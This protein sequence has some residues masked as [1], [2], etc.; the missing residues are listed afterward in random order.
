[1][2]VKEPSRVRELGALL[3]PYIPLDRRLA[4]A[5]GQ[6]LPERARGAAL[7][8]DISGFTPLTAVLTETL[9]SQRGAEVLTHQLNLVYG[10]LIAQVHKYG[11]SVVSFAG[12]A[13]TCWFD[14]TSHGTGDPVLSARL[15]LSCAQE[16]QQT[17]EQVD[18]MVTATGVRVPIS[19]KVAVTAGSVSRYHL[20]DPQYRIIDTLAGLTLDKLAAAEQQAQE[21]EIVVEGQTMKQLRT[22]AVASEWRGQNEEDRI[23]VLARLEPPATPR[24]WPEI[25][26]LEASQAQD[27]LLKPVYERLRR[28][29]GEYL[30][31]IRLVASLFIRFTGLDY[32]HDDLAGRKLD[33]Y[34][35]WTQAVIS[36]YQG[37][38]IQLTIGD[39]GSYLQMAFG[40]PI[41]HGD[42]AG[43]AVAA[44]LELRQLPDRLNY[45][46]D[47]QIGI[48]QGTMRTGAYGG[49][50]RRSY[51]VQG[52][53]VNIAARLMSQAQ[54]GQI[55][56]TQVISRTAA[57]VNA[58]RE[59]GAIAVKG[60]DSPVLT[61]E[62]VGE[63]TQ[64][65]ATG[66]QIRPAMIGRQS[67]RVRLERQLQNLKD[68]QSGGAI[69]EGED[70]I[71]KSR[72]VAE[73]I[74]G[75]EKLGIPALVGAGNSI[76]QNTAYHAWRSI[77]LELLG[78]E[79]GGD[80]AVL[81]EMVL[82]YLDGNPT[83]VERAPLLNSI[84]PVG[85]P[86][87][88]LTRGMSGEVRASN[89]GALLVYLLKQTK[90]A[91]DPL[92][93]ILDDAQWLDSASW[94]L[95]DRVRREMSTLLLVILLR[96]FKHGANGQ[97]PPEYKKLQG[98]GGTEFYVLGAMSSEEI[99]ALV[100]RRLGVS[101][102]PKAIQDLILERAEGH[103]LFSEEI[104]LALRDS[105]LLIV[106]GDEVSLASG[107]D[108]R[109]LDFPDTIQG[110]I[111]SRI[112][113]LEPG[114]ELTLKVASVI[115]RVFLYRTLA[116][117]Y[118]VDS[119][120]PHLKEYLQTLARLD[121]TPIESEQPELSYIFRNAITRDVVYGL[122][123]YRQRRQLHQLVANWYEETYPDDLPRHS[124]LLA[125]H[126]RQANNITKTLPYLEI[127]AEQA[128]LNYANREAA[129]FLEDALNLAE[130]RFQLVRTMYGSQYDLKRALW[131]RQ[132]GEAYLGLG[133]MTKSLSTL[134]RMLSLIQHPAPLSNYRL[135]FSLLKQTTRQLAHRLSPGRFLAQRS[136]VEATAALEAARAYQHLAQIY[137]FANERTRT[138][139]AG[140]NVLNLAESIGPCPELVRAYANMIVICG[141]IPW[142]QAAEAYS[143]RALDTADLVGDLAATAWTN[144]LVGTY[145]VG[146]GRWQRALEVGKRADE[147]CRQLGD[148]HTLGLNLG[149]LALVPGFT[150]NFKV[151][152]QVYAEWHHIAVNSGN[153]QHQAFGL[154]GQAE[155]SLPWGKLKEA[156]AMANEGL[157]LL[158]ETE[159]TAENRTS[160]IRGYGILASSHLR[161]GEKERALQA[162]DKGL[163]VA[164]QFAAPTAVTL[165]EGLSGM[166]EVYLELWAEDYGGP[167]G[168]KMLRE[169]AKEAIKELGHFARLFTVGHPR[170]LLWQGYF[171]W[172][173]GR[174][175]KAREAWEKSQ[176]I[177]KEMQMP[178]ELALAQLAIGRHSSGAERER[179]LSQARKTFEQLGAA[180]YQSA[181]EALVK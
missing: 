150:G 89:T 134:Q 97:I 93:I 176:I 120:R 38:L 135:M 64:T 129:G 80:P 126:W 170:A 76:E 37:Y 130:E 65:P 5:K 2:S 1:M 105:G 145:Q 60:F 27:W 56:A 125:F 104:A 87:S 14:E 55:L 9:G 124:P 11:G 111:I 17:V 165:L 180:Y 114:Q 110:I 26:L 84:L 131:L 109:Q 33:D 45:I 136:G 154:F 127:A 16:M 113:R 151:S 10:D 41:T 116:E 74:A 88:D 179:S 51:G 78:V 86:E 47:L 61:F 20:G 70:G 168:T 34:I 4:L 96:P 90:N 166:A 35:R 75:A 137:Y 174:Q 48:S 98:T 18:G 77:L 63:M 153:I 118:P 133:R 67:E 68:G 171:H 146:L 36:R 83:M 119:D 66:E 169:G 162:A 50:T 25:P 142:H 31:E 152:R 28:G 155:N 167:S 82:G 122:L 95:L 101:Q 157:R 19:L 160:E 46:R 54:P 108:L 85:M 43:R 149:L 13:L 128:L 81:R 44:A 177:A 8:V 161:Q 173:N 94:N 62:A 156:E 103:P 22:W 42:D 140:L 172:L 7:F 115:G 72:L 49:P 175:N 40:A 139:N 32:D 53:Q 59:I 143:R 91:S 164:S 58:F 23:A 117:I 100:S 121:I 106:E 6:S 181:A 30:S 99:A 15:A 112:D 132:L 79:E 24:P 159:M 123:L 138:L 92:V 73:I 3:S 158:E 52:N 69:I 147:I 178:H 102:L 141:L 163:E 148:T 144:L 29:E 57:K 12:D 21:G 39:K 107:A 71:G